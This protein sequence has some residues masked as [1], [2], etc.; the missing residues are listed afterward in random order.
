LVDSE[1]GEGRGEHHEPG[2]A[3]SEVVGGPVKA[4]EAGDGFGV[5]EVQPV[6]GRGGP[7]VVVP[8]VEDLGGPEGGGAKG[9]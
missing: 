1:E 9:C 2:E 7:G 5:V 4:V 8:A 3:F 6:E